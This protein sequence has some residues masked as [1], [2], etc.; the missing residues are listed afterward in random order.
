MVLIPKVFSEG[1][2]RFMNVVIE[3]LGAAHPAVF[4]GLA[5]AV[6]ITML[7]LV[8]GLAILAVFGPS[9]GCGRRAERVLRIIADVL[10]K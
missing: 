7:I 4:A 6:V 1:A 2:E 9:P 8:V 10:R 5:V 3:G